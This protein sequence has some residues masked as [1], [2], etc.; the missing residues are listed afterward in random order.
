[1]DDEIPAIQ[2]YMDNMWLLLAASV[3]ILAISYV[4]WGVWEAYT[5]PVR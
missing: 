1:M 4:A 5:V 2:R 3:L